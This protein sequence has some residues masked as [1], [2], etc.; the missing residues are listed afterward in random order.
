MSPAYRCKEPDNYDI[1]VLFDEQSGGAV[2]VLFVHTPSMTGEAD[3]S[4]LIA[5]AVA[6][7]R[8]QGK[9]CMSSVRHSARVIGSGIRMLPGR[10]GHCPRTSFLHFHVAEQNRFA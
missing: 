7:V 9:D 3:L 6:E 5:E 2:D 4:K 8:R 10:Q 1:A